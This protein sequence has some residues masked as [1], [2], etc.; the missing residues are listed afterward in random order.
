MAAQGG[1]IG[2]SL[3]PLGPNGEHHLG[4]ISIGT[5]SLSTFKV[6]QLRTLNEKTGMRLDRAASLSGFGFSHDGAV[7]TLARF[8]SLQAFDVASDQ[9]IADLAAFMLAFPGSDLPT[10]SVN[11]T[12]TPPMSKDTHAAVGQQRK[13]SHP[14]FAVLEQE[15]QSGRIDLVA[16]CGDQSLAYDGGNQTFV[17]DAGK[18]VQHL[19]SACSTIALVAGHSERFA[20]DTDGDGVRDR[21]EIRRGSHPADPTSVQFTPRVGLWYNPSRPGHGLDIQLSGSTL[22]ATWYTYEDDGTPTWYQ[23]VGPLNGVQWSADLVRYE[24]QDAN[25]VGTSVAWLTCRFLTG[26]QPHGPG[27]SASEPVPNP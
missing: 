1:F 15:A 9:E 13:A 26:Q 18:I 4:I 10:T 5:I 12:V 16:D 11:Y 14:Q 22:V 21:E 25:V 6:P 2:G 17:D 24:R 19:D 3:L 20:F 27:L 23:A 7:D 8:L